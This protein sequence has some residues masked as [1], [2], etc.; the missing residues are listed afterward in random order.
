M[1]FTAKIIK[2][3]KN[4]LV[5]RPDQ[6]VYDEILRKEIKSCEVKIEDERKIT[7]EQRRKIFATIRDISNYTGDSENDEKNI[8]KDMFAKERKIQPFS[9][10]DCSITLARDFI[11]W[12]IG[13]CLK[14]DI[15]TT[16]SLINRAEDT[17]AY[18]Y[19]C[20]A[21]RKCAVCN[22]S[23]ADI[24]HCEGSRIGMGQDRNKVNHIGRYAVALCREHHNM[25]HM[26]EQGFF[27]RNHIF[28]IKLDKYLVE[29]ARIKG[30]NYDAERE[31]N[32]V[33]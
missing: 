18:L 9:L 26:D 7:V 10:S 16:T 8:M 5:L 3:S 17:G 23:G 12:L 13:F 2:N 4:E 1:I 31:N 22:S 21:T 29:T 20:I 30:E 24:H 33:Y 28:G 11:T 19:M 25:A 15:G 14:N 27:E 6:N 32:E